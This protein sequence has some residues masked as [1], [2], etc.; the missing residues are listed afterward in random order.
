MQELWANDISAELSVDTH[1]PD[2]LMNR[3]K[4]DKH[5]WIIIIK[6]DGGELGEKQLKFKS[7]DK[8]ED[9]D[10]KG[11]DLLGFIRNE[12]RERHQR[13]GISGRV[14]LSRQQSHPE[15]M[16][17]SRDKETDVR[18]LIAQHRG[19]KSNRRHVVEACKFLLP[20]ISI[21]PNHYLQSYSAQLRAQDLVHSLLDGPIAAIEVK[22]DILEAI[23]DTRLSDPDSWRKV[24]QNAPVAERKYLAQVHELLSDMAEE[25]KNTTRNAFIYNFRTGACIYYDLGRST[26]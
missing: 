23:R 8:K 4:D 16:P 6:H 19:K 11:S 9:F 15:T 2:E 20:N 12:I 18:V 5:S 13:E 26:S 25:M 7:M 21:H 17:A 1:S 10:I 3:Y 22:D 14:K 24:I